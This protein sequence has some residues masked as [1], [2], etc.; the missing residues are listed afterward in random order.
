MRH[1]ISI[2]AICLMA[3]PAFGEQRRIASLDYC[4]DQYLIALGD[5]GMQRFVSPEAASA[6]SHLRDEAKAFPALKP[7]AERVL[8]ADIDMAIR[9][10]GGGFKAGEALAAVDVDVINISHATNLND[11]R[12]TLLRLGKALGREEKAQDIVKTFDRKRK[13]I[14]QRRSMIRNPPEVLYLTPSGFTAGSATFI[15]TMLRLAGVQNYAAMHGIQGYAQLDAEQMIL[16]PPDMI[17]TAFFDA[18]KQS[19]NHWSAVRHPILQD[20][21]KNTPVVDIPGSLVACQAWFVLDAVEAIQKKS[22]EQAISYKA[23]P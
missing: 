19:G 14:E 6:Y 13:A 21:L 3:W 5:E 11:I 10:W 4:A 2:L 18:Q 23:G 17:I 20:I 12:A 15:D 9:Q 16:N 8:M 22:L 1:A 7:T